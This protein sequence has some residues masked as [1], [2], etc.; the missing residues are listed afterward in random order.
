MHAP[1]RDCIETPELGRP[2]MT[3]VASW[4]KRDGDS[5]GRKG[6]AP[7]PSS[8]GR[9]APPTVRVV[10]G[11]AEKHSPEYPCRHVVRALRAACRARFG[12]AVVSCVLTALPDVTVIVIA[13]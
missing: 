5:L 13:L 8:G 3:A 1:Q 11:G 6:W 4:Q 9:A 12:A 2:A 10:H 7:I